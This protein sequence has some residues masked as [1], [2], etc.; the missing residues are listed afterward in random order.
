MLVCHLEAMPHAQR[1]RCMG[2]IADGTLQYLVIPDSVITADSEQ[3]YQAFLVKKSPRVL[4]SATN[5]VSA[6]CSNTIK[7][8]V[9]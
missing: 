2:W 8:S 1:E 9:I 6:A 5:E 7:T 3:P 4:I